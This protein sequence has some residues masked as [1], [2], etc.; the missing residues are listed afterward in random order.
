MPMEAQVEHIPLSKHRLLE[1]LE[2]QKEPVTAKVVSIDLDTRAST[3]TEMLER[4][5]AQ[6]L[7]ER[8]SNQRPRQY[9]I[10]GAG[11]R[12]LDL[13]PPCEDKPERESADTETDAVPPASSKKLRAI[14]DR[15]Q[16][17][18]F[19]AEQA[20]SETHSEAIRNLYH[21]RYELRSLGFFDSKIEARARIAHLESAVGKE[22]AEQLERLV[23]L[24]CEIR[25]ESG[26]EMLRAVIE[27]REA[28]YLSASV[29]GCR[30]KV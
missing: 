6:G 17:L 29:F 28:L 21:A 1:F 5:A 27:L 20:K 14:L 16:K 15:I 9:T 30:P 12:C 23:S 22:A 3:V 25:S 13:L 24:E 4:C 18:D 19:S 11:R 10:T 2:T 26:A 7:V 8:E